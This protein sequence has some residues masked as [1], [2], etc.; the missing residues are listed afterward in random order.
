M[1]APVLVR[2]RHDAAHLVAGSGLGRSIHEADHA[3]LEP[4]GV[5]ETEAQPVLVAVEQP[6]PRA[7]DDGEHQQPELVEEP[8]AHSERIR[9]PLPLSLID[10]VLATIGWVVVSK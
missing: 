2:S 3:T 6:G 7:D 8:V 5:D 1:I 4:L 10:A 9:V